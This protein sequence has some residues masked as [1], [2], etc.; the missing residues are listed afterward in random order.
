MAA[1][2]KTS[3]GARAE[4]KA[5]RAYVRR[6]MARGGVGFSAL[7]TVLQWVLSRQ[8]RYDKKSGGLGRR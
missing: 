7:D 5:I 2:P 3:A 1:D 4:R 8:A 6:L